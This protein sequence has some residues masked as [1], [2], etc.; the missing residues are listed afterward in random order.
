[1]VV[2]K[3]VKLKKFILADTLTSIKIRLLFWGAKMLAK[4]F[5]FLFCLLFFSLI[6]F[7]SSTALSSPVVFNILT[8]PD[9][10]NKSPFGTDPNDIFFQGIFDGV[11]DTAFVPQPDVGSFPGS[12]TIGSSSWSNNFMFDGT[13]DGVINGAPFSFSW[14]VGSNTG[15]DGQAIFGSNP[16]TAITRSFEANG[17][18]NGLQPAADIDG[19]FPPAES[20]FDPNISEQN[21]TIVNA[22]NTTSF[23]GSFATIEVNS[24]SNGFFGSTTSIPI[25]GFYI[26]QGQDPA[27]IFP[28]GSPVFNGLPPFITR[29]GVVSHFNYMMTLAPADWTVLTLSIFSVHSVPDPGVILRDANGNPIDINGNIIAENSPNI[30]PFPQTETLT[31]YTFYSTDPR[32]IAVDPSTISTVNVPLPTWAIFVILSLLTMTGLI[33]TRKHLRKTPE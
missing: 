19:V 29:D 23:S 13:F 14:A 11:S 9:L 16:V 31:T 33:A 1:M 32:A 21:V 15:I 8:H 18:E 25:A 2:V 10:E 22:D 20:V 27:V 28:V 12:N 5:K 26:N 24:D 30:V 7:T 3:L 17:F 4:R 6:I